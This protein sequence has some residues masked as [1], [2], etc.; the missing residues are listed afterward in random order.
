MKKISSF[1][2]LTLFLVPLFTFFVSPIVA[3]A[4]PAVNVAEEEIKQRIQ[5]LPP[6]P[7]GQCGTFAIGCH[8]A[9]LTERMVN[10]IASLIL[11]LCG[12]ILWLAGTFLNIVVAVTIFSMRDLVANTA[13]IN[14]VW[15][16]FRDLTNI[17]LI[18]IIL[19][20][21][22]QL[23]LGVATNPQKTIGWIILMALLINFSLFFT[24]IVIDA[25][26][27]LAIGFYQSIA[28]QTDTQLSA[29]SWDGG[30]SDSLMNRLRIPTI[31]KPP[32][33]TNAT[34][35][36][37][38]QAMSSIGQRFGTGGIFVSTMM[39]SVFV[40]IV[41]FVVFAAA[42]M[43]LIRFVTLLLLMA[44]SPLAFAAYALPSTKKHFTRWF[45][46]LLKEAFF[47]PILFI[48]LWL[49]FRFADGV[50]EFLNARTN[51]G[52]ESF[53]N[54]T[55]AH[56]PTA[57]FLVFN[58]SIIIFLFVAA[59][60]QAKSF[61]GHGSAAVMGLGSKLNQ[62]IGT[63]FAK[64]R[65]L[66]T[67]AAVGRG[68]IGYAAKSVRN[69]EALKSFAG[70]SR[71]AK[72]VAQRIEEGAKTV[73][74][75]TFGAGKNASVEGKE[76]ERLAREKEYLKWVSTP[77]SK[78][79]DRG[80]NIDADAPDVDHLNAKDREKLASIETVEPKIEENIMVLT[81]MLTEKQRVVSNTVTDL[82][83]A[84]KVAEDRLSK[85]PTASPEATT[86]AQDIANIKTQITAA[87]TETPEMLDLK[88]KIAFAQ[89]GLAEK[90]AEKK[91]LEEKAKKLKSIENL[92]EQAHVDYEQAYE[93]TAR[94]EKQ[95]NKLTA[96]MN[97]ET[98]A[99]EKQKIETELTRVTALRND[100]KDRFV[101][102]EKV[103]QDEST[104]LNPKEIGAKRAQR[105]AELYGRRWSSSMRSEAKKAFEEYS[106]EVKKKAAKK[107]TETNRNPSSQ[108]PG[109]IDIPTTTEDIVEELENNPDLLARIRGPEKDN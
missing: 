88:A 24:K 90:N 94:Y 55:L 39:G 49:A 23:I 92:N 84:L 108:T 60:V 10:Y 99:A 74:G 57:V 96:D 79:P 81:E 18:F 58:Y 75:F 44:L 71:F 69:S 104:N 85:A 14:I 17:F 27:I 47:A 52:G 15:T 76:K 100:A 72:G 16:M 98:D 107:K 35:E 97:A 93:E 31:Y 4:Q 1:F 48:L 68:T 43:L 33:P 67:G 21:A 101:K 95:V 13:A 61:G 73:T 59:L 64:R 36:I 30:L 83:A 91:E 6:D 54:A 50:T 106:T 66:A 38:R 62:K 29:N 63:G 89:K 51:T 8:L 86:A 37:D 77:K 78:A 9:T 70:T 45:D 42:V 53:S 20:M 82:N 65:A 26:N 103:L 109:T 2:I 87:E 46:T 22:F 41:A 40:L 105:Q 56:A 7:P 5:N 80:R 25:S 28:P 12:W 11:E 102:L 32:T 19:Y 34:G 3:S